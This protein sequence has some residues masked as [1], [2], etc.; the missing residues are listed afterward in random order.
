MPP[1]TIQTSITPAT[2]G[3]PEFEAHA[4]CFGDWCLHANTLGARAGITPPEQQWRSFEPAIFR[5]LTRPYRV[6]LARP[7]EQQHRPD[8]AKAT[9]GRNCSHAA[10]PSSPGR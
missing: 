8:I 4:E 7:P 10:A 9:D 3:L 6:A 1:R 2:G 5:G